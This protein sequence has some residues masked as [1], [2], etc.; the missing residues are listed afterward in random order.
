MT[1]KEAI[2]AIYENDSLSYIVHKGK[3]RKN[4]LY[5]VEELDFDEI[6]KLLNKCPTKLSS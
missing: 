1:S 5:K 2:I 6:E 3:D 4:I